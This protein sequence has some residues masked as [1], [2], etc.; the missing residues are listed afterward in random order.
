[1]ASPRESSDL[2]RFKTALD[3]QNMSE[4]AKHSIGR[5]NRNAAE[6]EAA[7]HGLPA[8][9]AN[10]KGRPESDVKRER[11]EAGEREITAK[12]S[13]QASRSQAR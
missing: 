8:L 1:M 7:H 3:R 9:D 5:A 2:S 13:P 11:T 4:R 6:G 12:K 10:S